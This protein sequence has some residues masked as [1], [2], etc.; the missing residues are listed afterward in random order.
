MSNASGK[1]SKAA[2]E[3]V[4]MGLGLEEFMGIVNRSPEVVSRAP[5]STEAG[6]H[7]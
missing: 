5:G 2:L 1:A 6:R 4:P 7:W 3:R